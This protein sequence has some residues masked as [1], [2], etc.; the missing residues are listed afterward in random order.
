[1]LLRRACGF[2]CRKHSA[3]IVTLIIICNEINLIVLMGVCSF[4]FGSSGDQTMA[5]LG[6]LFFA[7]TSF[8]AGA[9][10][11]KD[12]PPEASQ[13]PGLQRRH[14][15][16]AHMDPG[17]LLGVPSQR[18]S[19]ETQQRAA[20]LSPP[21]HPHSLSSWQ[22]FIPPPPTA[23]FQRVVEHP[24]AADHQR[25]LQLRPERHRLQRAEPGEPAQ[26]RRGQCH[27]E[28]HGHQHLAGDAPQPRHAH[29]RAGHDDCNSRRLPLQ[30]GESPS[31]CCSDAANKAHATEPVPLYCSPE[32]IPMQMEVLFSRSNLVSEHPAA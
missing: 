9:A 32:Q 2:I 19:G 7:I 18:R 12:P 29:Q 28:D 21:H 30:Q 13:R 20:D 17:G 16:A 22:Q 4:N 24:H 6:F 25:L 31:R 8:I 15:H 27:Q 14:L 26:L 11:H 23:G 10:R 1:M 3:H 5:Q